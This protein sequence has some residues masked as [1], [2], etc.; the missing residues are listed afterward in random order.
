MSLKLIINFSKIIQKLGDKKKKKENDI[1]ISIN[2]VMIIISDNI[3]M[4]YVKSGSGRVHLSGKQEKASR[5]QK[6][7]FSRISFHHHCF[8]V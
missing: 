7:Q 2:S 3:E 6:L 1:R 8:Q 4:G 5:L